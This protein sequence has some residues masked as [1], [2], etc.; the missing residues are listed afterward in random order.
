MRFPLYSLLQCSFRMLG[1]YY[2]MLN[3]VPLPDIYHLILVITALRSTLMK[4]LCSSIEFFEFLLLAS[5]TPRLDKLSI[6]LNASAHLIAKLKC[7]LTAHYNDHALYNQFFASLNPY[8]I[9]LSLPF[10][11]STV[12]FPILRILNNSSS[13][14]EHN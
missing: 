13:V 3:T 7:P 14:I 6:Y 11:S 4:S 8:P 12:F 1:Q 10:T 5:W 2:S 9:L